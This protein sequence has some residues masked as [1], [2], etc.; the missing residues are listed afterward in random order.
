MVRPLIRA[1]APGTTLKGTPRSRTER[2]SSRSSSSGRRSAPTS[3][4]P[5]ASVRSSASLRTVRSAAVDPAYST[6]VEEPERAGAHEAE[7][8]GEH[9]IPETEATPLVDRSPYGHKP[10][11][12]ERCP[13]E[14]SGAAPY[15]RP[16]VEAESGE[17]RDP[18]RQQKRC[19][20]QGTIRP[21]AARD[22]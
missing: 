19:Q 13:D 21:G 5:R 20:I 2:M 17:E 15:R 11:P 8:G 14:S 16:V 6:L 7:R 4:T 9:Y 3:T 12:A 1:K 22:P 10:C 18:G